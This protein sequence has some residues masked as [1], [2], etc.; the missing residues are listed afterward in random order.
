MDQETPAYP[1]ASLSAKMSQY[2]VI[3]LSLVSVIIV[4]SSIGSVSSFREYNRIV[5]LYR[6]LS[7]FYHNVRTSRDNAQNYFYEMTGENLKSYQNSMY[8]ASKNIDTLT[9]Q[10]NDG[11]LRFRFHI[12][13]NMLES[14]GEHFEELNSRGGART[15]Y[16]SKYQYL[17]Y[18]FDLVN[19]TQQE[20]YNYLVNYT[21]ARHTS[22]QTTW[23][24][25]FFAVLLVVA[26]MILVALIFRSNVKN[27]ELNSMLRRKLL[28][29]ENENLRI[30]EILIQSKLQS[31]QAQMNPHFLFNTLSMISQVAA[32][33]KAYET[34]KLI[35]VITFMLRYS[36]DKSNRM[37]TLHEEIECVRSYLYIQRMRFGDRI[38]FEL[39]IDGDLPNPVLPGMFLQPLMENAVIHGVNEMV[40]GALVTVAVRRKKGALYLSVEDNGKGIPGEK[41]EEYLNSD[42]YPDKKTAAENHVGII[43][44]KKRL[45]IL[46]GAMAS[47]HIESTEDVGTLVTITIRGDF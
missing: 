7:L 27:S 15:A 19:Y 31:L 12:L 23:L 3:L 39:L 47:F 11:S 41:L 32:M 9:A 40:S 2:S 44:A 42:S 25:L 30:N 8:A 26:G 33:E 14:C 35:D 13:R 28:E 43:N 6:E 46:Y 4:A 21:E 16:I 5:S 1:A 38:T 29:A 37:S 34:E 22:L 17:I 18:V 10:S 36:L 20:Y 24:Q 45:E